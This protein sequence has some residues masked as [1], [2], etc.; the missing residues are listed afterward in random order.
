MQIPFDVA[1]AAI[2]VEQC[3]RWSPSCV[4]CKLRFRLKRGIDVD[5]KASFWECITVKFPSLTCYSTPLSDVT[6]LLSKYCHQMKSKTVF[7]CSN[8]LPL[9]YMQI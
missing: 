2:V 8:G 9:S 7:M 5:H 6:H 1:A 4:N 3:E